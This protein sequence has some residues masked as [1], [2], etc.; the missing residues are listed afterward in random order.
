MSGCCCILK[1]HADIG[2]HTLFFSLMLQTFTAHHDP[3]IKE[4]ALSCLAQ[5][6]EAAPAP[7]ATPTKPDQAQPA[8]ATAVVV[9]AQPVKTTASDVPAQPVKAVAVAVQPPKAPKDS[10]AKDTTGEVML[11]A[12]AEE[13]R[14]SRA[15]VADLKAFILQALKTSAG[16]VKA[17]QEELRLVKETCTQLLLGQAGS[18]GIMVSVISKQYAS[19]W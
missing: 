13:L 2:H 14:S 1:P 16:D 7:T 6:G 3:R 8:K 10:P 18:T 12:M 4:A 9:A 15:E 19:F 11:S 17:V 5:L